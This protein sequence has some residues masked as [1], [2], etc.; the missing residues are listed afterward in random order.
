M[1]KE[2]AVLVAIDFQEAQTRIMPP[3]VGKILIQNIKT[4]IAF[5]RQLKIPK[6]RNSI[7]RQKVD[8]DCR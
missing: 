3:E 5:A 1:D 6:G 2:K 8:R 7:E 4:L